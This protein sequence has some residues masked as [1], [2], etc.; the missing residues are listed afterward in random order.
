MLFRSDR[1]GHVGI[2]IGEGNMVHS[3]SSKG[4]IITPLDNP[5]FVKN[6]HSS[7]R[8]E[9]Y[10]ALLDKT[11]EKQIK[12]AP[13]RKVSEISLDDLTAQTNKKASKIPAKSEKFTTPLPSQVFASGKTEPK[14]S[15]PEIASTEGEEEPDYD[16]FD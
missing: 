7:G 3:S 14:Q 16:F 11:S 8:V 2:Y 12:A 6:Y 5:Y 15:S 1:V 4:V 10:Y 13:R 9:R